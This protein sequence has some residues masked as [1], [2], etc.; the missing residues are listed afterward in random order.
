MVLNNE[1]DINSEKAIEST[2][3]GTSSPCLGQNRTEKSTDNNADVEDNDS[4]DDQLDDTDQALENVSN[5]QNLD[6]LLAS[7]TLQDP[8]LQRVVQKLTR[9]ERR[10]Q[11]CQELMGISDSDTESDDDLL[12]DNVDYEDDILLSGDEEIE[13]EDEDEIAAMLDYIENAS[14]NDDGEDELRAYYQ[15]LVKKLSSMDKK[16]EKEESIEKLRGR[17][18]G[19][20]ERNGQSKSATKLDHG[21]DDG[22]LERV[23]KEK[24]YVQSTK[25]NK[26][27]DEHLGPSLVAKYTVTTESEVLLEPYSD[28]EEHII[29][30]VTS[31]YKRNTLSDKK[32]DNALSEEESSQEDDDDDYLDEEE[33]ESEAE[34]YELDDDEEQ[35][36]EDAIYQEYEESDLDDD[37]DNDVEEE[38][39]GP[40]VF[41]DDDDDDPIIIDATALPPS[42]QRGKIRI[43]LTICN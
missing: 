19:K 37:A 23:T 11:R 35:T 24:L 30:T 38:E 12:S 14:L 41:A 27:E 9:K 25:L 13:N 39:D 5:E 22:Y 4:S 34:L 29:S 3:S 21:L 2:A 33:D 16:L 42:L 7:L 40:L 20:G 6:D 26:D 1:S 15:T 8:E 43:Y 10:E 17:G 32:H 31:V 36:E 18:K 28:E